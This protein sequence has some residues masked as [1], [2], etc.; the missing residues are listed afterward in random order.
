MGVAVPGAIK[1]SAGLPAIFSATPVQR[2]VSALNPASQRP[3]AWQSLK[4]SICSGLCIALPYSAILRAGGGMVPLPRCR[5]SGLRPP[6]PPFP[7]LVR[8]SFNEGGTPSSLFKPFYVR[9]SFLRRI[10]KKRSKSFE[11]VGAAWRVAKELTCPPGPTVG[12]ADD[13]KSTSKASRGGQHARGDKA[14]RRG[15]GMNFRKKVWKRVAKAEM[16]AIVK[17]VMHP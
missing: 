14:R 17:S 11:R 4:L 12:S 1:K 10:K 9:F 7:C 6:E 3:C 13:C 5:L 16:N 2:A 15:F 8:R